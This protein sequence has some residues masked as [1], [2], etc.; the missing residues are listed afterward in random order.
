MEGLDK[1]VILSADKMQAAD[2]I[3]DRIFNDHLFD[4]KAQI[5]IILNDSFPIEKKLLA[6][7]EEKKT[8]NTHFLS[9]NINAI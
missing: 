6:P 4:F 8:I 5:K 3:A 2:R 9:T 7:V 1:P